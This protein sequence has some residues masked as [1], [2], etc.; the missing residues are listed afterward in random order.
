MNDAE[1]GLTSACNKVKSF[2][3][4][5]RMSHARSFGLL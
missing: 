4:G 5:G 3:C 1:A 2:A